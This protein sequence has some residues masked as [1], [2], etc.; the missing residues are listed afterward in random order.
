[1]AVLFSYDAISKL[2]LARTD[3]FS[4]YVLLLLSSLGHS[5]SYFEL[6]KSTGAV[7]TGII[8]GLRAVGVFILSHFLYCDRDAG[9]CYT[10]T[11]GLSTLIVVSGVLGYAWSKSVKTEP[12]F[13]FI[14]GEFDGD[15]IDDE[16]GN[17]ENSNKRVD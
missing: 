2:D 8:Q 1:M 13:V 4:V 15:E 6:L 17:L 9:Q 16:Y 10:Y 7:A 14:S 11:K 12:E 3:V 5:I